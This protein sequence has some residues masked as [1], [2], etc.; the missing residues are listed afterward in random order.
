MILKVFFRSFNMTNFR[1]GVVR[2]GS[3]I[4]SGSAIGNIRDGVVR[5]GQSRGSGRA[6]GN[7]RDGVVRDGQSRGS[8]RALF[9]IKDGVV[10]NGQSGG[11]GSTI[12]KVKYFT[13]F[14]VQVRAMLASKLGPRCLHNQTTTADAA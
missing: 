12:G 7:V 10:R 9:N 2:N 14:W 3:S 1:D 6:L 5:D 8:G 4:G 11:S 13:I